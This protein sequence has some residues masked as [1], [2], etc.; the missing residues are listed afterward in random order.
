MGFFDIYKTGR[1][2]EKRDNRIMPRWSIPPER[3]SAEW[4]AAFGNNPRFA[5][6]NKIASDLSYLEGKLYE[7][8]ECGEEREIKKHPFL[9]FWECPN[10][11]FEFTSNAIW[12]LQE[13]YLLLKG[14]GYFIIERRMDGTPAELWPVPPHWVTDTPYLN[15]PFYIVALSNGNFMQVSVDDMFV[16]KDMNPVDPFRRGL[17]QG[18]AIADEIEIDEY[19]AKFQKKFFYNDATPSL[20]VG[21]PGSQ[22]EERTRFLEMWKNKFMGVNNVAAHFF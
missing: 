9:D 8:D 5:V 10:P 21:M 3:N 15:N 1:Y 11:L 7:V 12:K 13:I 22:K 6:V 4:M 16:M 17:G 19:A 18:E 14:E 20:L 2:R